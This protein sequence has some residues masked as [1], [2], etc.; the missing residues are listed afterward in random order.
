[1]VAREV[2]A[3]SSIITD[4]QQCFH[5]HESKRCERWIPKSGSSYCNDHKPGIVR[6]TDY[7]IPPQKSISLDSLIARI[8]V[9][10][11]GQNIDDILKIEVSA[12]EFEADTAAEIIDEFY[13]HNLPFFM[14]NKGKYMLNDV[15][16]RIHV[17]G[18]RND[19]DVFHSMLH[20]VDGDYPLDPFRSYNAQLDVCKTC[21]GYVWPKCMITSDKIKKA[22][23]QAGIQAKVKM[24]VEGLKCK[25]GIERRVVPT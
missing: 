6:Y 25:G 10:L 24:W 19:I 17:T 9:E 8:E 4:Y 23:K 21:K 13:D 1:M 5:W 15:H 20:E 16:F 14:A 18:S 12:Q 22:A 3:M 2:S 11:T 7:A